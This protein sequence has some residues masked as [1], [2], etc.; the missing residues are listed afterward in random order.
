M[1]FGFYKFKDGLHLPISLPGEFTA[2]INSLPETEEQ[3]K[4]YEHYYGHCTCKKKKNVTKGQEAT[5]MAW[6]GA[7][8]LN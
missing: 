7:K 8:V 2:L 3:W 5:T 6:S 1:G 4:E